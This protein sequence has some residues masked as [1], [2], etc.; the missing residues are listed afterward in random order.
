MLKAIDFH[1]HPLPMLPD[2]LLLDEVRA[3][4]LEKCVLLAMDV[5]HK[6]L[7]EP[8][9]RSWMAS[10][11]FEAGSWDLY[12]LEYAKPLLQLGRTPNERVA[13]LVKAHPDLFVGVGSVNPAKGLGHVEEGLREI[14][15]LGLVGVKLLPT[16]QL[17][18]PDELLEELTAIFDFCSRHGLMLVLHTGCDPGP[19][20]HPALSACARPGHYGPLISAY[21]DVPVVLAHAGSYSIR[22]PGI[23][24]D[25]A[26]ELCRRNDH[27][28]LDL[29]AVTYLA[30][31]EKFAKRI[32]ELVGFDR[33]LFGSDWPTVYRT[34]VR[35]ALERLLASRALSDQE[36]EAV[37]REN[38]RELL[39]AVL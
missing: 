8:G 36:K 28:W 35:D 15:E 17:F 22:R 23:W 37:A 6:M 29:A 39:K 16:L 20:E 25:E 32:R 31:E 2:Q 27:V 13:S 3:S 14:R 34:A 12:E 7:E 18:D 1:V 33:V 9:V 26:L 4:G 38:A 21:P 19:W 11:L 30:V 24:L 5:D 10:R